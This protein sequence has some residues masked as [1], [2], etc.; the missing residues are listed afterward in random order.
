MAT[1]INKVDY[2]K[3]CTCANISGIN[4]LNG[5]A[6]QNGNALIILMHVAKSLFTGLI[7]T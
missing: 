7:Q 3:I 1:L 5:I 6:E 4:S 2:A